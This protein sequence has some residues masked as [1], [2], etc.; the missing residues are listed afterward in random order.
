[1]LN[2]TKGKHEFDFGYDLELDQSNISN[3]DLENGSFN[4]TN[5]VTGLAMANF[6]LGYQ[7]TFS[8]TSGNFSDSR[9]NP[10]GVFANDKWKVSP[11]LT[12]DF[13]LRW[14]PQQVMKE[15]SGDASSS[16]VPMLSWPAFI[17]PSFPARRPACSS[18]AIIQRTSSFPIAAKPAT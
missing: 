12:L 5:D 10:M 2:W 11:R 7:H 16:S 9:E 3:T 14:E 4:F 1:M 15:K 13:G 17:R 18:S 8:Q 6:L